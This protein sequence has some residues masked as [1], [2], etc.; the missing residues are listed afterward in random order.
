[1]DLRLVPCDGN[2]VTKITSLAVDLDPIV[3]ELLLHNRKKTRKLV[4]S[5]RIQ[6]P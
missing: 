3:Q 2:L 5:Q 4:S 6:G 1:M